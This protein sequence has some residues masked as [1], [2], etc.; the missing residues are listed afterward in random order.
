MFPSITRYHFPRIVFRNGERMLWN[1]VRRQ[2]LAFRPEE[3]VRLQM[4]DYLLLQNGIPASRITSEAPLPTR[5][6]HGRTDLLCYDAAFKPWLLIECKAENVRLGPKAA[7]QSAV[8]NRFIKAPFIMLTN[9]IHDA[10]FHISKKQEALD[11]SEYPKPL[12]A[13]KAFSSA[14]PGYWKE[15]GFLPSGMADSCASSFADHLARLFH[16]SGETRAFLTFHFPGEPAPFSHYFLILPAPSFPDT[17]LAFSIIAKNAGEAVIVA[18]ANCNKQNL[19]CFKTS[20]D[21]SGELHSPEFVRTQPNSIHPQDTSA[22][23]S[24]FRESHSPVSFPGI[25]QNLLMP[26]KPHN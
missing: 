7:T 5:F 24:F 12:L 16:E 15:R 21:L 10:L 26:D 13:D 25:L 2:P 18:I 14:E 6:A 1:P 8:Y 3:R 9:G 11:L 23:K 20:I 22:L 19:A 4:L 17:L